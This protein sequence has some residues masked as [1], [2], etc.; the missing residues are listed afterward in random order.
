[1]PCRLQIQI[2]GQPVDGD[3]RASLKAVAEEFETVINPALEA[4]ERKPIKVN[5]NAVNIEDYLG[6][7]CTPPT[8]SDNWE[9]AGLTMVAI[10]NYD[11]IN[12]RFFSMLPTPPVTFWLL[13]GSPPTGAIS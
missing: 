8:T 4:M 11:W 9:E 7:C 1:M 6:D 2:A 10:G 5:S 13:G 3:W 12:S